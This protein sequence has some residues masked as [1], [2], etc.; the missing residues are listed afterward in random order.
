MTNDASPVASTEELRMRSDMQNAPI[1]KKL[2][3]INEGGV[4]VTGT[5]TRDIVAHYIEWQKV[6]KRAIKTGAG[7]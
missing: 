3:L 6:P 4:L 7:K 5:L 1:G 2:L